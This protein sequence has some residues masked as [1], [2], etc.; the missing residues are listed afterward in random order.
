MLGPT[1]QRQPWHIRQPSFEEERRYFRL[2]ALHQLT[3]RWMREI[4]RKDEL[5]FQIERTSRPVLKQNLWLLEK[6]K[7][8][9]LPPSLYDM[10]D[11]PTVGEFLDDLEEL[12]WIVQSST[13]ENM[14]THAHDRISLMNVLE[15]SSWQTGR[16]YAE[17][18]WSPF[19]ANH[20]RSYFDAIATSPLGG[21]QAFVLERLTDQECS[22][23]WMKSPHDRP[24]VS[25]SPEIVA[26]CQLYH[27][28]IRGFF[29]GLSR[30]LRFDILPTHLG[31]KKTWK[32]T[33][34][35]IS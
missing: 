10:V 29:Y 3:E 22:F 17:S 5:G 4:S 28:W 8:D 2:I 15:K 34:Q 31:H 20:I 35:S 23:Y 1:R 18:K 21:Q 13:L 12:I 14:L 26:H 7:L 6:I 16:Q 11:A 9:E 30:S 25:R 33:I 32:I 24:A 19:Q 27:E